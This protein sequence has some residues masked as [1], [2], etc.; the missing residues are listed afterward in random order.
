MMDK[1]VCYCIVM[2]FWVNFADYIYDTAEFINKITDFIASL[3]RSSTEISSSRNRLQMVEIP[4]FVTGGF[5][6]L[7]LQCYRSDHR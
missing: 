4:D 7:G 6:L 5:S 3:C 2:L 1:M